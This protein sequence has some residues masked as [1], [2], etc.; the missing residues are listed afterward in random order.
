MAVETS[1][2]GLSTRDIEALFTAETGASLLSRSAVSQIRKQLWAEYE[3]FAR[4]DLSAFA[5]VS[6]F[7]DGIAERLHLGQ[8]REALAR[9]LHDAIVATCSRD[10]P[11]AVAC[12][13]D[14]FQTY[15]THLRFPLGHRRTIRTTNLLARLFD[16]VW[17]YTG[18]LSHACG[19]RTV[20]K[21][22]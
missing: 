12:P 18:V 2:H 10:L 14:D 15:T 21:L 16:E 6:L 3:E 20:L 8:P 13:Q 9:L 11:S 17:R 19:E 5:V 22:V 4:R 1:T 7:V